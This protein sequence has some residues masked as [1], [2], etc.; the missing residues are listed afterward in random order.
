MASAKAILQ[1]FYADERI[2]MSQPQDKAD[3]SLLART[4]SSDVKL[5]QSPDLPYGGTY[6]GVE[7]FLAWG[8]EMG[9]CFDQVGVE[10][11]KILEDGDD[12][13][14]LSTLNLRVRKTGEVLSG[15]FAQHVKVDREQGKIVEMRPFYWNVQGLNEALKR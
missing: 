2:Y 14:V 8:K 1:Q 11:N 4:L 10:P 13:V 5:Y 15:P 6:S 9:N 7:G 3:P 12:V